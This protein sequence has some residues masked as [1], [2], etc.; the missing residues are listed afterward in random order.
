MPT[1]AHLT[2][3]D[4]SLRSLLMAQLLGNRGIRV[5]AVCPGITMSPAAKAVVPGMVVDDLV[6]ASLLHT[7]LEP[8]DMTGQSLH[9]GISDSC[10]VN[11]KTHEGIASAQYSV[12]LLN[13]DELE[14]KERRRRPDLLVGEKER[15]DDP[16]LAPTLMDGFIALQ[17]RRIIAGDQEQKIEIRAARQIFSPDGA[18][19]DQ[20]PF[21]LVGES[22]FDVRGV[23]LQEFLCLFRQSFND[24]FSR[25]H[26]AS[27][28]RMDAL[29]SHRTGP[30]EI[31]PR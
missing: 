15:S 18:S 25:S 5:N 1:V 29:A 27:K 4:L 17:C 8:E 14:R 9:D 31:L 11:V 2:T 26:A 20:E 30:V 24:S 22:A 13:L 21:E 12:V 6:R 10:H 3:V 23:D 28:V 7:T 16:F 19:I